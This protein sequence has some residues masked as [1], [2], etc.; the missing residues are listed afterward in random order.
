MLGQGRGGT[1]GIPYTQ[2]ITSSSLDTLC[3]WKPLGV[4][5]GICRV[6]VEPVGRIK[7]PSPWWLTHPLAAVTAVTHRASWN[8]GELSVML[9]RR[10][11]RYTQPSEVQG[12]PLK[13]KVMGWIRQSGHSS[14]RANKKLN[15]L[16]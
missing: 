1:A 7:R 13:G 12:K 3:R 15:G 10:D 14:H 4:S 16:M 8:D 6:C 2:L 11:D 5:S 9:S